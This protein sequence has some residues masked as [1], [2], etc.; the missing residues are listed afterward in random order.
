MLPLFAAFSVHE[1]PQ[2]GVQWNEP[3][4]S[5]GGAGEHQG[6]SQPGHWVPLKVTLRPWTQTWWQPV[7]SLLAIP[8]HP[9]FPSRRNQQRRTKARGA[10]LSSAMSTTHLN[11]EM[12]SGH[13]LGHSGIQPLEW[14]LR[15]HSGEHQAKARQ[16][17]HGPGWLRC[18]GRV[19]AGKPQE[20][21]E[22]NVGISDKFK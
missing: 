22:T 21:L 20:S 15:G 14:S 16:I 6:W 2:S 10:S 11:A 18:A 4:T 13:V 3:S 5:T 8:S 17:D 9:R 12:L 1:A 19:R 7:T